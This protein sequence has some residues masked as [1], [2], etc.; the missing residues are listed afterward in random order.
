MLV[1]A[2]S[3]NFDLTLQVERLLDGALSAE[4]EYATAVFDESTARTIPR[5]YVRLL[6][7]VCTRDRALF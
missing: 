1:H 7:E 6:R 4:P 3:S 5:R 2:R